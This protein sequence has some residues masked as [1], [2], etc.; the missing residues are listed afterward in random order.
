LVKNLINSLKFYLEVIFM[1]VNL[2]GHTCMQKVGV[3]LQVAY[4]LAW[5]INKK[6]LKFEIQT[7]T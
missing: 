6:D 5:N 7:Q 2:C 1:N 4:D 3:P